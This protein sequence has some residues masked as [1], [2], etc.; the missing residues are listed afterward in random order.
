MERNRFFSIKPIQSIEPD[1]PG[2]VSAL[3]NKALMPNIEQRYQRVGE[4]LSDLRNAARRLESSEGG[5]A[6]AVASLR[7]GQQTNRQERIKELD[8]KTILIV[9]S[10]PQTQRSLK[11]LM[12]QLQFKALCVSSPEDVQKTFK[13]NDLAAQCILFNGQSLGIRA[14][15]GFNDFAQY[16]G[17]RDVGAILILDAV[18]TDW[19]DSVVLAPNRVIMTMPIKVKDIREILD[20]IFKEE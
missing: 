2:V 1:T 9:D 15:R 11:A 3:V 17:L 13:K 5:T 20:L 7:L 16:R 8:T 14:V 19:M 12:E 4:M 10:N 6:A 18:Q